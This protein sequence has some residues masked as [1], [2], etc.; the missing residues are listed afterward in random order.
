MSKLDKEAVMNIDDAPGIALAQRG[1]QYLHVPR[2]HDTV[3][4]CR[5]D[6][7]LYLIESRLLVGRVH[8]HVMIRNAVPLG[9][10]TH[11]VMIGNDADDI[12]IQLACLPAIQQIH[13][14]VGF[15]GNHQHHAAALLGVYQRPLH[16]EFVG[17]GLECGAQRL[18]RH[19]Q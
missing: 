16:V 15:P 9:E 3:G 18:G 6:L 17:D 10:R 5:I 14:A 11:V 7:G 2:Q 4:P 12:A 19:A 8:R 1:G 13:Q